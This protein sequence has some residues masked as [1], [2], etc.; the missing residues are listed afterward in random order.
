M[1]GFFLTFILITVCIAWS[2]FLAPRLPIAT[3]VPLIGCLLWCATLALAMTGLAGSDAD[4]DM[5]VQ[6]IAAAAGYAQWVAI[7]TAVVM[8]PVTVVAFT[9]P[10]K[11]TDP[12]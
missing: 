2:Q 7:G 5:R 9:R 8:L 3:W 6:R 11:A 10:V 1:A 4:L 12:P